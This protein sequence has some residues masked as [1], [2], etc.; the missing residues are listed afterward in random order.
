[1]DSIITKDVLAFLKPFN[2]ELPDDDPENYYLEREWRKF[3]CLEFRPPEVEHV[4]IKRGFVER[5]IRE[6]PAY[7]EKIHI[8]PE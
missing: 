8:A 1:M 4:L 2:S 6:L 5:L 3:G 7:A